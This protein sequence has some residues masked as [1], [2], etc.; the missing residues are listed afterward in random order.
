ME[1]TPYHGIQLRI[2]CLPMP[3][4]ESIAD[5]A[6]CVNEVDEFEIDAQMQPGIALKMLQ[7]ERKVALWSLSERSRINLESGLA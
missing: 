1:T 3:M 5:A 6:K 4:R 7:Q 2:Q